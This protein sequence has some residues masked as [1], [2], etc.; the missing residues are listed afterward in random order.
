[1]G[2]LLDDQPQS[3][4]VRLR[5]RGCRTHPSAAAQRHPRVREIHPSERAGGLVSSRRSGTEC[6][7]RDGVQPADRALPA[8][9]GY[10]RQLPLRLP[11]A[12]MSEVP[13]A[14]LFD[15]DGTLIDS[16]PD[17][18]GAGNELRV[19][20]G[21]SPLPYE[22]FRPM[23]GSGARGMVGIALQL[24]PAD[25]DFPAARDEFLRRYEARMTRETRVFGDIP[26][27]LQDLQRHGIP[28]GIV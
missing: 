14:V 22:A 19:A 15:L 28:W 24:G 17:L 23:V 6:D 4:G 9:C 26:S 21:L 5:D 18:A 20:R 11:E 13:G 7:A 1:M 10:Q 2:L 16:A 25:T 3:E 27:L 8:Q 12:D